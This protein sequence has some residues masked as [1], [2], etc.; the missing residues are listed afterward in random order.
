RERAW[1]RAAVALGLA[2]AAVTPPA[3][4]AAPGS[5][6]RIPRIGVLSPFT[7]AADPFFARLREGLRELGYVE[8]RSVALEYR[9]AAGVADRLPA[10]AAELVRAGVDVIVTTTP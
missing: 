5:G 9:A 8:G 2:L 6:G 10:L 3:R 1:L 7:P 4:G